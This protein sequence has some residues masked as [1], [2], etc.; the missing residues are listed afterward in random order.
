MAQD[1][2]TAYKHSLH[3]NI[4]QAYFFA[5]SNTPFINRSAAEAKC[6]KVLGQGKRDGEHPS[7]HRGAT[8]SG[9]PYRPGNFSLKMNQ[10]RL[11]ATKGAMAIGTTT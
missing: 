3:G 2:Y 9:A 7:C 8:D 1:Q 6:F 5:L 4:W 10:C 11:V